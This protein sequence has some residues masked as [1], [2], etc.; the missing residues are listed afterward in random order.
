[1]VAPLLALV[2]NTLLLHFFTFNLQER[3]KLL[4]VMYACHCHHHH[5]ADHH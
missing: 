5:L 3:N 2:Q 1:M 4:S